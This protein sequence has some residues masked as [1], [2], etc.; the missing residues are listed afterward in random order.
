MADGNTGTHVA[1]AAI[2]TGT[3]TYNP[4]EWVTRINYA[5]TFSSTLTYDLAG[6]VTR[7]VYGHGAAA[8]KTADYAYDNLYRITGF[9]LTGGVSEDFTYDRSGNFKTVASGG[10]TLT[11]NY[12]P[13]STPNR[14]DSTTGTGGQTYSY[15][16]N[17]WMTGKGTDTLTYDYRGLTTGYGTAGYL[18][19]PDSRRVKKTAGTVT[20]YY[21]RG[22]DGSILAEYNGSQALSARYVYAGT[23]RIARI[24]GDSA[25]YYLADHLGSTRSLVDEAG[26]VTA[27]YDYRPYGKVL[28]SSGMD[29]NR[30]RFTG[31]ERDD[32]SGLDYMLERSYGPNIGRF[33]KPDPMQDE[34]PGIS[35]YAYAANNPLKYVDPDGRFVFPALA[36]ATEVVSTGYDA[37]NLYETIKDPKSTKT[38]VGMAVVGLGLGTAL[39]GPGSA[40]VNVLKQTIK[41]AG[42]FVR[43]VIKRSNGKGLITPNA[44]FSNK[45]QSQVEQALEKRFGPPRNSPAHQA[46]GN[47]SFFNVDSGTSY[48]VHNQSGHG[49]THVDIKRRGGS[50]QDKRKVYLK[51]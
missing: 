7:Q 14:L 48:N 22:T 32:E 31:H 46:E 43:S 18:M 27:T 8:S 45:T 6:N 26:T 21:L 9:D 41:K 33:L 20:T 30:F 2:V 49:P 13:A 12:S 51:Q 37:Y 35:P 29:A 19:D 28:S 24:A 47:K 38:D 44:Y 1:D 36:V 15:N 16:P 4:R 40:Y 42:D 23:R 17:G 25:N 5:G 11:Y 39:P 34:Y 10:S 3:Y 50:H